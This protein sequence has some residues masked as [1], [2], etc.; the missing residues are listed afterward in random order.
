MY[1]YYTDHQQTLVSIGHTK[2]ISSLHLFP[3]FV[4]LVETVSCQAQK[5]QG[6]GIGGGALLLEL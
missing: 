1:K 4:D 3:R 2:C 5:I 6:S